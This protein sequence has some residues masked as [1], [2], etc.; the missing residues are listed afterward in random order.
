M[1]AASSSQLKIGPLVSQVK[2]SK[3]VLKFISIEVTWFVISSD[4]NIKLQSV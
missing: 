1:K 4:K 3:S 2:L